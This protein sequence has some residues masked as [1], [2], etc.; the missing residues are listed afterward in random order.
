MSSPLYGSVKSLQAFRTLTCPAGKVTL[1]VAVELAKVPVDVAVEGAA[2]AANCGICFS[3]KVEPT[4]IFVPVTTTE[5]GFVGLHPAMSDRPW[6][7]CRRCVK[8]SLR[9]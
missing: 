6:N 9:R 1:K 8:A 5:T 7:R 3:L 4:G 2:A